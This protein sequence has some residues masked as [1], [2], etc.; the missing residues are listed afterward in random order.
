[1]PR[2]KKDPI[3]SDESVKQD[4]HVVLE[5]EI[6]KLWDQRDQAEVVLFVELK[7]VDREARLRIARATNMQIYD[8]LVK[9]GWYWNEYV[10]SWQN[11]KLTVQSLQLHPERG[12]KED[13]KAALIAAGILDAEGNRM[14]IVA[15]RVEIDYGQ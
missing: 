2:K 12:N 7:R 4:N 10:R 6:F 1:M 15:G 3:P 8:E 13:Y 14:Q 5:F 11:I 9:R